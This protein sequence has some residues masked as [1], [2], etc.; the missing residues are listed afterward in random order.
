MPSAPPRL[1]APP[2]DAARALIDLDLRDD[3]GGGDATTD[4]LVDPAARARA[5][6]VSR[7]ELVVAGLAIARAVFHQV[8]PRLRVT[9]ATRDGATVKAGDTLLKVQGGAGALLRAERAALNF[10]QRLSGVATLTRRYVE[11]VR[12]HPVHILDTRKTIP[13]WRA[14]DKYAVACGGGTNHRFGLHDRILIKDNHLA[15]WTRRRDGATL[16][17]AVRTARAARP[18]LLVEVEAD[19]PEQVEALLP[20]R[21]D[22]ILLDNMTRAE[23]RRCVRLCRGVCGTEAS[24]GVNLRTVRGIAATG[25]DAISVGALTHSAVAVDIALDFD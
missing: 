5:R 16:A 8:D 6:V 19:T 9:L 17:D 18:D 11:A 1:P 24:G 21:P 3:L 22:W 2:L 7:Q 23:L 12:P 15:H 4:S 13:G 10:L 14:L 20:A 25:V